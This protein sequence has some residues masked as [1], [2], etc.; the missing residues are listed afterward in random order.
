M[1]SKKDAITLGILGVAGIAAASAVSGGAEDTPG[2]AKTWEK[3]G[4]ILG[5]LGGAA[6]GGAVP[7]GAGGIETPTMYQIPAAAVVSFP[8]T[9]TFDFTK[10]LAPQQQISKGV[11][12]VSAAPKKVATTYADYE[13]AYTE[14]YGTY[15]EPTAKAGITGLFGKG[16]SIWTPEKGKEAWERGKREEIESAMYLAGHPTLITDPSGK[17]VPRT[18]KTVRSSTG[19]RASRITTTV[20]ASLTGPTKKRYLTARA[21]EARASAAQAKARGE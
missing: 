4:G 3:P 5:V 20:A 12:G 10:F 14:Y 13:R 21:A 2:G 15:T 6:P 8:K 11:A 9:P 17:I 19:D 7:G 16:F 1:I 18:K